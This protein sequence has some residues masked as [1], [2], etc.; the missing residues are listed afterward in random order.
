MRESLD[1]ATT[2]GRQ[3]ERLFG[4]SSRLE[5]QKKQKQL[6]PARVKIVCE[7]L[8]R[9]LESNCLEFEMRI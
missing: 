2:D 5:L 6:A 9:F 3:A 1:G 8:D 4:H 7:M